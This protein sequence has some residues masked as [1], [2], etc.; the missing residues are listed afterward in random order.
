MPVRITHKLKPKNWTEEQFAKVETRLGSP[1]P[2]DYRDFLLEHNG[3]DPTPSWFRY[4]TAGGKEAD[5]SILGFHSVDPRNQYGSEL[6]S[7]LGVMQDNKLPQGYVPIGWAATTGNTQDQLLLT[8]TGDTAGT[9]WLW[10][11]F[12]KPFRESRVHRLA[13]SFTELLERLDY[14]PSAR[15]WMGLIDNDDLEGLRWWL[16]TKPRQVKDPAAKQTPIEYAASLGK[17]DSVK[18][19]LEHGAKPGQAFFEAVLGHH[20]ILA[21]ELLPLGV[22]KKQ[23][24]EARAVCRDLVDDRELA[25]MVD[26]E[27]R[28]LKGKK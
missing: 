13:G 21:K 23:L 2:A 28:K 24:Q 18:L 12:D 7:W 11:D 10:R 8:I 4:P 25:R 22:D 26:A 3:G 1:L 20:T 6:E 27:L 14:P 9:V 17:T 15:P 5:G 16:A 19:L